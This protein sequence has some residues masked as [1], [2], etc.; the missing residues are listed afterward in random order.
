MCLSPAVPLQSRRG[1]QRD[2]LARPLLVVP[3]TLLAGPDRDAADRGRTALPPDR[4]A[5]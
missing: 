4:A 3:E 2:G 1:Q 5:R